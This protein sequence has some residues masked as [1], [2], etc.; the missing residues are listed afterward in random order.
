[1][2]TKNVGIFFKSNEFHD[3]KSFQLRRQLK[4][5]VRKYKQWKLVGIYSEFTKINNNKN[6]K[7][8]SKMIDDIFNKNI[9]LL[10]I[11]CMKSITT[12]DINVREFL[13]FLKENNVTIYF[14]QE[15]YKTYTDSVDKQMERIKFEARKNVLNLIDA[16]KEKRLRR[17]SFACSPCLGYK[18]DKEKKNY[19]IDEEQAK[20]VK[21]IFKLYLEDMSFRAIARK[22]ENENYLSF[23][24]TSH[25]NH[26]VI[27]DVI[28]NEKYV[29][30]IL[31]GKRNKENQYL[32]KN[33]HE[34]IID[35][36]TFD[37]VQEKYKK[38]YLKNKELRNLDNS[39]FMG[40][41]YCNFCGN[42]FNVIHHYRNPFDKARCTSTFSRTKKYCESKPIDEVVIKGTF[43][44]S[45]NL[46]LKNYDKIAPVLNENNLLYV[47]RV[48]ER[49]QLLKEFDKNT[50]DK[51]IKYIIIGETTKGKYNPYAIKF[52]LK[53]NVDSFLKKD[54]DFHISNYKYPKILNYTSEQYIFNF[55]VIKNIRKLY[56]QDNI[57]VSVCYEKNI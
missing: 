36:E 35:R 9:Q 12:L 3:E 22:L 27:S 32:L 57:K 26:S 11:D 43:V 38:E 54:K 44:E 5:N 50:F 55:K 24:N 19:V 28:Q 30:D 56:I 7:N 15:N 48:L 21:L 29:G 10:V 45:Y 47:N 39:M 49:Q 31:Y 33:H 23:K 14:V 53:N 51:I 16:K 18:Y 34:A 42:S 4:E 20:L 41:I 8:L 52:V 17:E 1:M 6:R 2:I 25:W 40:K 37:K 46:L 13:K